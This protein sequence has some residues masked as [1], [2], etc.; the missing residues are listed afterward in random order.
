VSK[1]GS[2]SMSAKPFEFVPASPARRMIR[3]ALEIILARLRI[4]ATLGALPYLNRRY[5]RAV[6]ARR[7]H[8]G[9]Y[10]GV[11]ETYAEALAAIPPSRLAGWDHEDSATL[12]LDQIAPVKLSSYPVFFWL[13]Q[14]FTRDSALIDLGGAIGLTYYGYRRCAGLPENATWTVIEVP[15]LCEQGRKIA[16]RE[17]AVGLRFVGE[18]GQ[19]GPAD[20]LLSAGALQYIEHSIPGVLESLPGKP[21]FVLLNKLPVTDQPDCWTLQNYGPAVSPHRLFNETTLLKYFEANGYQLRDRWEVLDLDCLI[22]FHPQRFIRQFSGF[23]F[24]LAQ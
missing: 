14:L 11:F 7:D 15:K 24:E 6:M 21:R 2:L 23:L 9:L 8:T 20:I 13:K 16:E 10:A 18:S 17:H 22:P 1:Y 4:G 12:W 5:T 3:K 19:A